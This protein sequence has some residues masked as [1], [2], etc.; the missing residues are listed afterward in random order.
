MLSILSTLY[1][2]LITYN[3]QPI[4]SYPFP[5]YTSYLSYNNNNTLSSQQIDF[6]SS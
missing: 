4:L 2:E 3:R 6:L 5:F 1:I